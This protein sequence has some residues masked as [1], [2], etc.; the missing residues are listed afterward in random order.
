M[1]VRRTTSLA[2]LGLLT[3][4]LISAPPPASAE[5]STCADALGNLEQ[6]LDRGELPADSIVERIGKQCPANVSKP[7]EKAVANLQIVVLTSQ[8]KRLDANRI[9]SYQQLQT[10]LGKAGQGKQATANQA[11]GVALQALRP[12]L[13]VQLEKKLTNQ[14]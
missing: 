10:S 1:N 9:E 11:F 7:V 6:F 3:I 12:V 14:L 4:A 13:A 8:V 5:E 2:L